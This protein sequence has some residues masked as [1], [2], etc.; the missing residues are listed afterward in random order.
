MAAVNTRT[1]LVDVL[2]AQGRVLLR[3]R[4]ALAEGRSTI[5][6]GR[7][8]TADV[9]LDDDY[10][11]ELHATLDIAPNGQILAND[12]GTLNGIIVAG[13]RRRGAQ[14]LLLP[15]GRLQLGRTSLRVRT[16][17]ASTGPEK[18]DATEPMM[19]ERPW[20]LVA[21]VAALIGAGQLI[22]SSWIGAP[23]DLLGSI[24]ASAS[25]I[26]MVASSLFSTRSRGGLD[27]GLGSV[28]ARHG[29]RMA[30]APACLHSPGGGRLR[31]GCRRHP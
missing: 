14:A 31:G 16:D 7:S 9:T 27:C 18:R 2:D 10:V 17:G 3:E 11:A 23:R 1:V 29:R 4:V 30:L 22:H 21:G 24:V 26:A 8:V 5:T 25:T 28:V 15:D 6:V 12:L 19:P 20:V 13:A